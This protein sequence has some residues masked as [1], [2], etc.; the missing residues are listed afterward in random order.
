MGDR[1]GKL[2]EDV[3]YRQDQV[4]RTG[5]GFELPE[6]V[7]WATWA[8]NF[9]GNCGSVMNNPMK[10][11]EK[12]VGAKGFEPSTSWSRTRRASQAALRPDVYAPP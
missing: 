5:L 6:S 12:V 7:I 3:G 1:Y 2:V 8:T 10:I 11:R 4:K 9:G